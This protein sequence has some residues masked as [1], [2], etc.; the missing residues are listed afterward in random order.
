VI[1][2]TRPLF[3]PAD[4]VERNSAWYS[5]GYADSPLFQ[6]RVNELS[7]RFAPSGQ[8]LLIVGCGFGYLVDKA[9]T[10]GYDAWG[11]DASAYAINRGKEVLP[12][13]ASRLIVAD[14]LVDAQVKAAA[15]AAGIPGAN[16][17]FELLVTEDLLTCLTDTEVTTALTVL[18]GRSRTN[19]LHIVTCIRPDWWPETTEAERRA[20]DLATRDPSM[21]WKTLTEW[22]AILTPPDVVMDSQ[23]LV[24]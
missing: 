10:L 8:K 15:T 1:I 5:S 23:G 11:I 9:V 3:E 12:A 6:G 17:R 21:N 18:R 19:L 13:I 24:T 2:A 22:R 7:R 14:A 20:R 16:P 4:E